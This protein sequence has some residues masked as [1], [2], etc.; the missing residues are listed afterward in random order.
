MCIYIYVYATRAL[1]LLWKRYDGMIFL[2]FVTPQ[3]VTDLWQAH[4][5]SVA[6]ADTDALDA[7]TIQID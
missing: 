7:Q 3:R 1:Q 4:C 2:V 6:P 5:A